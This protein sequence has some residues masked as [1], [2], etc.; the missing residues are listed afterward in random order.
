MVKQKAVFG[1]LVA[2]VVGVTLWRVVSCHLVSRCAVPPETLH[3]RMSIKMISEALDAYAQEYNTFPTGDTV[4]V[5]SAL[6]K[7][8]AS[9]QNPRRIT[10]LASHPNRTD[11][12]GRLLDGYGQPTQIYSSN[13]GQRVT[14][15][16]YGR[17]GVDDRGEFDDYVRV[18]TR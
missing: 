3:T 17:N 11:S 7:Y 12:L 9:D 8:K 10:F 4:E 15:H 13:S 16:S 6:R 1:V 5:I 14:V 2:V 18:K